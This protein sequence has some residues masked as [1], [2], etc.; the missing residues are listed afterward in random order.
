MNSDPDQAAASIVLAKVFVCAVQVIP[1]N[2]VCVVDLVPLAESPTTRNW[3]PDQ[4]T[5]CSTF[6][7]TEVLDVQTVPVGDVKIPPPTTTITL[8]LAAAPY[9][10]L[11]VP[12][13]RGVQVVPS[14]DVRIVPASPT[15]T[16]WVP[17]QATP[18]SR[19]VVPDVR[20]THD[21]RSVEEIIAPTSPTAT[22]VV[23]E[24]ATPLRWKVIPELL[25]V[26]VIPSGEVRIVPNAPTAT[27]CV[28]KTPMPNS[29]LA[30]P[31]V[32]TFQKLGPDGMSKFPPLS[33]HPDRVSATRLI[34]PGRRRLSRVS[35]IRIIG[36]L[37][38]HLFPEI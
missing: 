11:V 28:E 30:V 10:S 3:A 4:T 31:E 22:A 1:S 7:P 29:V 18:R 8:E 15:A 16:N 19:F 6:P 21:A 32:R 23:P 36:D 9:K 38:G 17:V 33:P 34:R 5:P 25:E 20:G 12:D 13:V 27:A 24:A 26:H 14:G 2:E 35:R 37:R